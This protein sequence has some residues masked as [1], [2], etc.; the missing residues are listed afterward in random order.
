[1]VTDADV[2]ASVENWT[3]IRHV[4]HFPTITFLRLVIPWTHFLV[5]SLRLQASFNTE[6]DLQCL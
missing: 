2:S 4:N 5:S 1:M 3:R 6:G